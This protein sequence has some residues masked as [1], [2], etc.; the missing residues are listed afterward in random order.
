MCL[1]SS[2]TSFDVDNYRHGDDDDETGDV[3][4][5]HDRLMI[6]RGHGPEELEMEDQSLEYGLPPLLPSHGDNHENV[7]SIVPILLLS[8]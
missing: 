4:F 6:T 7:F 3:S 5:L 1:V 8:T 2:L